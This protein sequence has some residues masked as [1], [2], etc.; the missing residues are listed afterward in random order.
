MNKD[1][2]GKERDKMSKRIVVMPALNAE[3]TLAATYSLIPK[4]CVD[5]VILVDDGSVD[6]TV[7][8]AKRLGIHVV[9]HPH[10]AGYGANQKTCYM[11]ALRRDADVVIMLHPDGQHDPALIPSMIEAIE[12]G[13]GDLVLAS[14]FLPPGDALLG[15]M[16]IYKYFFNRLLTFFEN[17]ALGLRISEYHTGYRA[18]SRKLL[19]TIPFLR[20]SNDFVCDQQIVF[21]T[22]SFGFSI[23]E[24]PIQTR[25]LEGASSIGFSRSVIYGLMTLGAIL[26]YLLFRS[27]LFKSRLF[28]E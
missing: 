20:N 22:V 11:E 5:E 23:C 16:P 4:D 28:K 2:L 3:K 15:G 24:L 19:E 25:Y 6:A 17:I 27:G 9:A 21:Q 7:D 8:I 18:Y 1:L 14:R 13:S 10:N 26:S 12:N